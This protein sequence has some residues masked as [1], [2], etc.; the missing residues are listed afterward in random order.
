[1]T[2]FSHITI[3]GPALTQRREAVLVVT[4]PDSEEVWYIGG[5]AMS[6]FIEASLKEMEWLVAEMQRLNTERLLAWDLETPVYDVGM[7]P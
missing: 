6:P 7:E 3:S 4:R 1:M 2:W 5:T